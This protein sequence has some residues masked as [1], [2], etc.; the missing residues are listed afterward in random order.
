MHGKTTRGFATAGALQQCTQMGTY[1]N[2]EYDAGSAYGREAVTIF[3][4]SL[5]IIFQV[6]S[7]LVYRTHPL[8][9][10]R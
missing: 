6:L 10:R 5:V 4:L 2:T 7:R 3:A 8:P 1:L 9:V